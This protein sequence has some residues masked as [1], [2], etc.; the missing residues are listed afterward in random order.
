ML[1]A[2]CDNDAGYNIT[3]TTSQVWQLNII[4]Y[5]IVKILNIKN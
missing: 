2:P 5:A 4:Q 1:Q 3:G